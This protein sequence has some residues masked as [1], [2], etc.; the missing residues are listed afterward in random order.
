MLSKMCE[1][2]GLEHCT[3]HSL[4]ATGA[5]SMFQANLPEDVIQSRTRHLS[6]KA[7]RT[8]ERVTEEQQKEACKVLTPIST[9]HLQEHMKHEQ[10]VTKAPLPQA[11]TNALFGNPKKCTINVQVYNNPSFQQCPFQGMAITTQEYVDSSDDKLVYSI[12]CDNDYDV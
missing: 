10:M 7:L 11:V 12:L 5:S 3:N 8:Y 6:L 4:C 9:N 1:E 2:A